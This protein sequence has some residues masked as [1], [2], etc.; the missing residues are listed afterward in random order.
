ML[1]GPFK[2]GPNPALRISPGARCLERSFTCLQKEDW[3]HEIIALE[4]G[5]NR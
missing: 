1:A 4:S 5:G 3:P 2:A